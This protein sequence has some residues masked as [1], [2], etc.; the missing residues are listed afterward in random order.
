MAWFL[1]CDKE[2]QNKS[3]L[4]F[5]DSKNYIQYSE[6]FC[7]DKYTSNVTFKSTSPGPS[8]VVQLNVSIKHCPTPQLALDSFMLR[9]SSLR[10]MSSRTVEI[11]SAVM[12]FSQSIHQ[13]STTFHNMLLSCSSTTAGT[14]P[15]QM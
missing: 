5:N 15:S 12:L 8:T 9:I 1:S 14:S 6:Q 10:T 3:F 11:L 13:I 7:I 2:R 4:I